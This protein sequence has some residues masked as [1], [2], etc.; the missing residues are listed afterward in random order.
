MKK[1]LLLLLLILFLSSLTHKSRDNHGIVVQNYYWAKEGKIEAVYKQRL[2]ASEVRESLGLAVG[3]VL[4]RLG[5]DGELSQVIWECEYASMEAREADVKKLT[6]SGAFE[7]VT[8][9]MGTLIDKFSR[10]VYHIN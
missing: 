3:R 2:Y 4:K 8:K 7:H 5:E 6:A 1:L 9:K 10:G